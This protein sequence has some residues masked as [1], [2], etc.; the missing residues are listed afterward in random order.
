VIVV[1]LVFAEGMCKSVCGGIYQSK[2]VP[3]QRDGGN[4]MSTPHGSVI[5]LGARASCAFRLGGSRLRKACFVLCL[6]SQSM[7][8]E[9]Y[10]SYVLV[11]LEVSYNNL[12]I[13]ILVV[14]DENTISSAT[15]IVCGFD[16]IGLGFVYVLWKHTIIC[17]S[18]Y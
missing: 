3:K 2:I 16:G 4:V 15:D 8:R 5:E 17:F 12:S 11:C 18:C 9:H 1:G 6:Q 14:G 13:K 7:N 10:R